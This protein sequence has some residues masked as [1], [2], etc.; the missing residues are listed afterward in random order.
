MNIVYVPCWDDV[1]RDEGSSY[2]R[3]FFEL[4]SGH[5]RA[6]MVEE[7]PIKHE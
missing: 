7:V 6:G 2:R 4:L 1:M 5:Y 3:L